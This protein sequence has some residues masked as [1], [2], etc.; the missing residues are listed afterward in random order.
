MAC[1]GRVIIL[2][3]AQRQ[4]QIF[5][6]ATQQVLTLARIGGSCRDVT[7]QLSLLLIV[8]SS[9][10]CDPGVR[11]LY[12]SGLCPYEGNRKMSFI[13]FGIDGTISRIERRETQRYACG[14]SEE[15]RDPLGNGRSERNVRIGLA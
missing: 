6:G 10:H 1:D 7:Q 12:T 4:V 5:V 9:G 11:R 3:E 8:A 13:S 2:R 14:V 15:T